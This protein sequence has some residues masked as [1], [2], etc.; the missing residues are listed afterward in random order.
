MKTCFIN[1]LF[2]WT[3]KQ[4]RPTKNF[5]PS[6]IHIFEIKLRFSCKTKPSDTQNKRSLKSSLA[7]NKPGNSSFEWGSSPRI[8]YASFQI[9][10]NPRLSSH[11]CDLNIAVVPNWRLS[12]KPPQVLLKTNFQFHAK[13]YHKYKSSWFENFS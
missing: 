7:S 4:S 3:T 13:H 5:Q 2:S 11:Q 8:S 6:W 10:N 12:I 1:F 9:N